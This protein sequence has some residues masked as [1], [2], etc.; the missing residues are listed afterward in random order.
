[1]GEV[2]SYLTRDGVALMIQSAIEIYDSKVNAPRHAENQR[3]MKMLG[4]RIGEV[5]TILNKIEGAATA[6]KWIGGL[7]SFT[8]ALTEIAHTVLTTIQALHK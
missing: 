7:A 5:C 8:W 2:E 6:F 1:V 4:E 3:E